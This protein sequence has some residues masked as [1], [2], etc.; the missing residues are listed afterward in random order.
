MCGSPI[1]LFEVAEAKHLI[2][3]RE[4]TKKK[5]KNEPPHQT[6]TPDTTT[7]HLRPITINTI[8]ENDPSRIIVF[9][10]I[11]EYLKIKNKKKTEESSSC[12]Y[13]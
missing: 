2:W 6:V 3:A 13:L 1:F 10:A 12:I 9:R 5:K 4:T 8:P 7:S 11:P